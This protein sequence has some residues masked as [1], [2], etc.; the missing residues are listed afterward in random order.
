MSA[1]ISEGQE[2]FNSQQYGIRLCGWYGGVHKIAV[3]VPGF[4]QNGKI[5][6]AAARCDIWMEHILVKKF[7]TVDFIS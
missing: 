2:C 5:G 7:V 1:K 6:H 3:G 4:S